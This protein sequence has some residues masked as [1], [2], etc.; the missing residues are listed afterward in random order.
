MQAVPL[1]AGGAQGALAVAVGVAQ[2]LQVVAL[3]AGDRLLLLRAVHVVEV[4]AHAVVA[5]AVG[6]QVAVLVAILAGE[7]D[8]RQRQATGGLAATGRQAEQAAGFHG[9]HRVE[10]LAQACQQVGVGLVGLVQL[11]DRQACQRRREHRL[12]VVA[13][14][15]VGEHVAQRLRVAPT[16]LALDLQALA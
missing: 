11:Q 12:Q 10:V 15:D 6:L 13:E 7:G 14:G 8:V 5:V 16:A 4:R 3:G 9:G 1:G 2:V